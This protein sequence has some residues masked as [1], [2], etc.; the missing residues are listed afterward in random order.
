MF[1]VQA[2]F[3]YS[4]IEFFLRKITLCIGKLWPFNSVFS[5]LF[6]KI[7]FYALT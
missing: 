5:N 3:F 2:I 1:Q 6:L 4:F 7:G